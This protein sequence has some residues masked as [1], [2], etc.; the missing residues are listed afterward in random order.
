MQSFN[1]K[2][3]KKT[4]IVFLT[5]YISL[6]FIG[7]LHFHK[8]DLEVRCSY[9][10]SHPPA[11]HNDLSPDFLSVCSLHQFSQTIDDFH[12]SS[13]DIVQSL[14]LLES[15]LSH[16]WITKYSQ[17]EYSRIAPRAPPTFFS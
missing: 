14:S 3:Q 7:T 8:F 12:Y 16:V 1:T 9:T 4:G 5:I 15:N 11:T 2:Y 13:S 6:L 17:E 10:E